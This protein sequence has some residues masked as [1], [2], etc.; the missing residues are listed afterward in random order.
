MDRPEGTP[1]CSTRVARNSIWTAIVDSLC[2]ARW[3]IRRR[4]RDG[5]RARTT[6]ESDGPARRQRRKGKAVIFSRDRGS[7]RHAAGE[8]R[9]SERGR[10]ASGKGGA[11]RMSDASGK[12]G[13]SNMSDDTDV[14]DTDVNDT[15]FDDDD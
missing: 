8:S 10:G 1:D 9:R 6:M 7:G 11:S 14:N 2:D 5:S 15:N 13:A 4:R 3:R 12:G